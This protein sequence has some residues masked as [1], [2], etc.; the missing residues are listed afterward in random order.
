MS[1]RHLSLLLLILTLFVFALLSHA[2]QPNS[3]D[4]KETDAALREKAFN[5]LESLPD[6]I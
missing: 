6:Q 3:S 1:R 4:K 2:Q 5:L